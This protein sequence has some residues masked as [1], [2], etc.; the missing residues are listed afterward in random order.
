[1]L[2]VDEVGVHVRLYK[3]KWKERPEKVDASTL[4]LGGVDDKDGFGMGHLPLTKRTF[5]RHEAGRHW[6]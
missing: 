6:T 2:A 3:N 4:S 5:A 1:M